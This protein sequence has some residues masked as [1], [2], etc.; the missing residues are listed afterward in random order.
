ML[1]GMAKGASERAGWTAFDAFS[2][3]HTAGCANMAFSE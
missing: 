2:P 1:L 3:P